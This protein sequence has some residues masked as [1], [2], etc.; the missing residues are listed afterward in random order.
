MLGSGFTMAAF[1]RFL[2]KQAIKLMGMG[3]G[4]PLPFLNTPS[5]FRAP[6]T[7]RRSFAY[8]V[9]LMPAMKRFGKA[10]DATI[11]DIRLTILDM[12]LNRYL[13]EKSPRNRKPLV[14]D[15]PLALGTSSGGNQI[16]V[17]QFPLGSTRANPTERL[18]EIC[19]QTREVNNQVKGE[20]AGAMILYTARGSVPKTKVPPA[21]QCDAQGSPTDSHRAR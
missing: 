6:T 21:L 5:A 3:K 13:N 1:Y 7:A 9:V 4:T 20:S 10:H 11:N 14:V 8:S 2:I 19:R 15:M 12:A 16:A 17:L 18:R